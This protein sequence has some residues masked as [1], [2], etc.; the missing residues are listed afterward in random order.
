MQY[1]PIV[2]GLGAW[3]NTPA[4]VIDQ[5]YQAL[6]PDEQGR[7]LA[8]VAIYDYDEPL[9]D[10][11]PWR[12]RQFMEELRAYL[13]TEPAAPLALPWITNPTTGHLQGRATSFEGETIAHAS[14]WILGNGRWHVLR[15]S[16]D[17]WYSVMD[18]EPGL[19]TVIVRHP[20]THAFLVKHW[21]VVQR[22]RVTSV[23]AGT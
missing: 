15:A 8:G 23:S 5:A 17:G 22:G 7:R 21:V 6:M 1:R 20:E 10:S 4:R 18:L 13:F 11:N 2:A 19:Y 14:V 16:V 9:L 3:F 12:R